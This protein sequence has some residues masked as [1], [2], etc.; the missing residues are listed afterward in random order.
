MRHGNSPWR[1]LN[2]KW[3]DATHPLGET[4]LTKWR[5]SFAF[6]FPK[7]NENYGSHQCLHWWQQYATGILRFDF[8]VSYSIQKEKEGISPPFLFGPSGETRTRG[9]LLPKRD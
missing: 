6:S 1:I 7:G 8:R 5:D 9:I 3:G 4:H 2:N